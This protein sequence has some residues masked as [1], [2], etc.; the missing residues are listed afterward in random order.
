MTEHK[1]IV[2]RT[3][4]G[5]VLIAIAPAAFASDAVAS[6]AHAPGENCGHMGCKDT[7]YIWGSDKARIHNDFLAVIDFDQ[8]SQ[9]YGHVLSTVDVGTTGNEAHHC[10]L[11]A[12]KNILACGGLLSVLKGQQEVFFFDV[13]DARHPV[14]IGGSDPPQSSITDDFVGLAGGGFLVTMMG[15]ASGGPGGRVA[16]YDKNLNLVG[17]WPTT[18]P[19]DGK[20]NPHGIS[21]RPD[22]N[23]MVTADFINPASTLNAV[24]GDV[25][26]RHSIRVWNLA[27]RTIVRTIDIPDAVGTMDVKLIPG[28]PLGRAVTAGMFDGFVYTVDT[29]T[30][31]YAKSFD[32]EDI[33]PHVETDVEGGMIQLITLPSDGLR[34]LFASFQAGQVG[35]LD[36]TDRYHFV[37]VGNAVDVGGLNAGPHN[38]ILSP[39]EKRLVV[40]NYFLDEDN[41]GKIHF[42]GN[43][44]VH[45]VDVQ[46]AGVSVESNFNLDFDTAF[47]WG[48]SRPHGIAIKQQL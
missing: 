24:P 41:F 25:E 23:L 5:A 44:E 42:D 28:D 37:Q 3:A 20:F 14:F 12:D 31:T 35:M 38:H 9:T 4:L 46:D 45:V 21:L 26:L 48:P 1:W 8:H 36:I 18:L 30:G 29:S 22:L 27:S 34:V 47:S 32:C 43:H 2:P 13:S 6:S 40:A 16:E 39:D 15:S 17:E 11:S 7:L 10:G 19:A 33:V